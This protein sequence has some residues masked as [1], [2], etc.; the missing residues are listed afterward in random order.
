MS[1]VAPKAESPSTSNFA[2]SSHS[3]NA[4]SF[5]KHFAAIS[6]TLSVFVN[7]T[8]A[9][10]RQFANVFCSSF[11]TLAGMVTVVNCSP[12]HPINADAP[13]VTIF[14]VIGEYDASET[15]T[16]QPEK[17]LAPIPVIFSGAA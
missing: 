9:R 16:S 12:L 14:S 10:L 13:I 7:V 17:A 5:A 8:V 11:V 4:P 1:A 15:S 3:V 6:V 2:G